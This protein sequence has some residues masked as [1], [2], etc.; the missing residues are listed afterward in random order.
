MQVSRSGYYSWKHRGKSK[1]E[2][3][4]EMLV[5][6]VLEANRFSKSTYGTRRMSDEVQD[7]GSPC[8]RYR[9]RTLMNM[10]G[11]KAK[12]KKKYKVTTDSKHKLPVAP[13]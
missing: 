13:N 6:I 9:A 3:E 8:G 5:P 4:N 1:R 11:V 7:H 12:Q 2:M 10:A